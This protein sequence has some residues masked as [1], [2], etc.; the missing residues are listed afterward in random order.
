MVT[1]VPILPHL[2]LHLLLWLVLLASL[3]GW[4]P[5]FVLAR[6]VFKVLHLVYYQF[7]VYN[8]L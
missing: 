1:C 7:I 3:L 4:N 2:L 6:R 8:L 5:V